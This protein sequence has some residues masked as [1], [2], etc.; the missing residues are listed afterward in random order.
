[1]ESERKE[2]KGEVVKRAREAGEVERKEQRSIQ[3]T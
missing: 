1:M 3:I 2:R